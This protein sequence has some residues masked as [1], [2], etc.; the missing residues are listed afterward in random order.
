MEKKSL[1]RS[2]EE[3]Q[4]NWDEMTLDDLKKAKKVLLSW[5]KSISE[6][7]EKK[8]QQDVIDNILFNLD[9]METDEL[10]DD[11]CC[12]WW[13]QTSDKMKQRLREMTK[14]L[15]LLERNFDVN[16]RFSDK[17]GDLIG[18]RIRFSFILN[19]SLL[20]SGEDDLLSERVFVEMFIGRGF[21]LNS[22]WTEINV[23]IS[24]GIKDFPDTAL[25]QKW[26]LFLIEDIAGDSQ[27]CEE[28]IALCAKEL[29]RI[30]L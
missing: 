23:E 1:K 15:H 11:E 28:F 24:D 6:A 5:N 30:L 3:F 13:N 26:M 21:I 16:E 4:P 10:K 9:D 25:I 19:P 20:S 17:G 8:M 2:I 14:S 22:D 18:E 27:S 29:D 12:Q 7:Q